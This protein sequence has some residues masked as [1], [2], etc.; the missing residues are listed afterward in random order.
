MKTLQTTSQNTIKKKRKRERERK[1]EENTKDTN[2]PTNRQ[3][4]HKPYEGCLYS[5]IYMCVWYLCLI[6]EMMVI[7][8]ISKV[9]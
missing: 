2:Q 6:Y 3:Q 4:K 7:R 8:S 1:R 5:I 9:D